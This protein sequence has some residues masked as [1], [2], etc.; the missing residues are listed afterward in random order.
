MSQTQIEK[1]SDAPAPRIEMMADPPGVPPEIAAM[2]RAEVDAAKATLQ[3]AAQ[4]AAQGAFSDTSN[5]EDL[6]KRIKAQLEAFNDLKSAHDKDHAETEK[7]RAE[8]TAMEAKAGA[9]GGGAPRP[10]SATAELVERFS[11]AGVIELAAAHAGKGQWPKGKVVQIDG[12]LPLDRFAATVVDTTIAPAQTTVQPV[13]AWDQGA[14]RRRS[15][16]EFVPELPPITVTRYPFL[17]STAKGAGSRGLHTVTTAQTESVSAVLTLDS[18]LGMFPGMVLRIHDGGGMIERIILT[19]D[20]LTQVTC[21]ANMGATIETAQ[22]VTS[23]DV[24]TTAEGTA[25]PAAVL[26]YELS[27]C[28]LQVLAHYIPLSV[29]ALAT[30]EGLE[31][32]ARYE[33]LEGLRYTR[34]QQLVTGLGTA[35]SGNAAGQMHGFTSSATSPTH[36]WSGGDVGDN[37]MDAVA[38]ACSKL[39]FGAP[40]IVHMNP[41]DVMKLAKVKVD[42]AGGGAYVFPSMWGMLSGVPMPDGMVRTPLFDLNPAYEVAVGTFYCHQ[43]SLFSNQ[44]RNANFDRIVVGYINDQLIKNQETILAET[45]VE[46]MILRPGA[47]VIGTMDSAPS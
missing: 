27:Y 10:K 23:V 44:I 4:A 14:N 16:V 29:Q 47:L 37:R 7:L 1:F 34:C 30:A 9:P 28:D 6:E 33:L 42:A 21:T 2:V 24:G 8:L 39:L 18:T 35:A 32:M 12:P 46:Q 5:R 15:M 3:A 13:Q 31:A 36:S 19:V 45:M 41:L 25:K 17:R 40:T 22:S 20:T 43:P 26:G 11:A 38:L